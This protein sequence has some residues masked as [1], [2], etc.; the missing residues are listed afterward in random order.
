[1]ESLW[2]LYSTLATVAWGSAYVVLN[3]LQNRVPPLIL[4]MMSGL[5]TVVLNGVASLIASHIQ[6][7]PYSEPWKFFMQ[8]PKLA[9]F[10]VSLYSLLLVVGGFFFLLAITSSEPAMASNI[11]AFTGVYTLITRLG[12]CIFL[13]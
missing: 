10:W 13:Q 1:M 7:Q 6:Q 9:W 3:P 5:F 8:E 2:I 11:V 12:N 4:Q